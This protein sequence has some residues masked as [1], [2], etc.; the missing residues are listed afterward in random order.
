M[1]LQFSARVRE[2]DFDVD[3]HL[4]AGTTTA[5]LGPNGAG[6][7]TLVNLL[8]GLLRPDDGS[9][10]LTGTTLFDTGR[11]VHVP[12]HR[13]SIG[14]LAQDP[15]LFPHL[16]VLDNVAFGPRSAGAKRSVAEAGARRWLAA[17]DA[18]EFA[19]RRPA[20]LSGGQAQRV[21]LARALAPSPALLL[22][23]EPMAA[24][25]VS[26]APQL[27]RMLRDVLRE[28]TTI[29]ITHDVLDAYTLADRVIILRKGKL[30]E[31][32]LTHDVLE[33]PQ[34]PFTAELAGLNLL[35]GTSTGTGLRDTHGHEL[36]LA[37]DRTIAPG[38]DVVA[39]FRPATVTITPAHESTPHPNEIRDQIRDLERRGDII[40]V[41]SDTLAADLTPSA[42]AALGAGI[43]DHV[44]FTIDPTTVA[45]YRAR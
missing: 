9:A 44:D 32:G 20:A 21:A 22:L 30:I 17:V 3:L 13:R 35:T 18:E 6:K 43:G 40:R 11:N 36:R 14:L 31:Q 5:V 34:N 45:L 27:R 28:R 12:P 37:A 33:R 42:L 41:R 24:L 38:L 10:V 26:V 7:S 23:D 16:T 1:T 4:D 25:D 29:L 2:R 19:S 8:A 15:L 39:S